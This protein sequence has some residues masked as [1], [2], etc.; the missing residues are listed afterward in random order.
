MIKKLLSIK[1]LRAVVIIDEVATWGGGTTPILNLLRPFQFSNRHFKFIILKNR[2][3]FLKTIFVFLLQK[4]IIINGFDP[5]NHY[6]ILFLCLFK[7]NVIIYPQTIK[8]QLDFMSRNSLKFKIL[9]KILKEKKIACVSFLQKDYF[10]NE[11]QSSKVKVVSGLSIIEPKIT[12]DSINI[13]MIGY[14]S[15]LKGVNFYSSLADRAKELGLKYKF[16]WL[17]D[18]PIDNLQFSTNVTW[19]GYSANPK[20]ILSKMDLFFLSSAE[21]SIPLVVIEALELQKRCVAFKNTGISEYIRTISGCAIYDSYDVNAA[22]AAIN[23]SLSF[24]LDVEATG[25]LLNRYTDREKIF[26]SLNSFLID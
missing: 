10:I 16:F 6:L 17:G 24:N 12:S 14:Y 3:G 15:K 26:N 20:Y 25:A 19:L 2:L 7:K 8:Y 11:F 1:R 18:G 21:E 22:I 23:E 13:C 4:N 5:L 9:K